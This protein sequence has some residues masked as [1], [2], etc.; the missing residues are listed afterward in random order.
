MNKYLIYIVFG[1]I[2]YI[3]LNNVEYFSI[4]I[5]SC[6]ATQQAIQEP[7]K[8]VLESLGYVF[9]ELY[10]HENF[11]LYDVDISDVDFKKNKFIQIIPIYKNS[12]NSEPRFAIE[13]D[14]HSKIDTSDLGNLIYLTTLIDGIEFIVARIYITKLDNSNNWYLQEFSTVFRNRNYKHLILHGMGIKI[15]ELMSILRTIND[16][17]LYR[18]HISD[19][20]ISRGTEKAYRNQFRLSVKPYN[21]GGWQKLPGE[22]FSIYYPNTDFQDKGISLMNSLYFNRKR[23]FGNLPLYEYL[24]IQFYPDTYIRENK[25][26]YN[27]FLMQLE[28]VEIDS[29]LDIDGN[30]AIINDWYEAF[31][32]RNY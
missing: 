23:I 29:L 28:E 25:E 20:S 15:M 24:F 3:I 11:K 18:M 8:E 19:F 1:L 6:A 31:L 16:N 26:K 17:L 32:L 22:K 5:P 30:I 7:T 9:V 2:V 13:K 27:H 14:M 12:G 10:V 4:G 21:R